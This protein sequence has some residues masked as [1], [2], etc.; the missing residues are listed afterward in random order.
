MRSRTAVLANLFAVNQFQVENMLLLYF[1]FGDTESNK[2]FINLGEI[3]ATKG[4]VNYDVDSS[5]DISQYNHVLV[6]CR[7]FK[8]LFSYAELKS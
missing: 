6:W 2:D 7:A 5:I 4:D 1:T 8:V 3:K